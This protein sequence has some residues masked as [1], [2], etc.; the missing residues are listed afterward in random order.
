MHT[1]HAALAKRGYFYPTFEKNHQFIVSCFI[2]NPVIFDYN[3]YRSLA[4]S[5]IAVRNQSSLDL[6]ERSFAASGCQNL[7][8]SSEHL[9]FLS[10]SGIASLKDYLSRSFVNI[11]VLLYLR[12]PL[13]AIGSII[14]ERVKN[15]AARIVDAIEKPPF[16]RARHVLRSWESAF[17]ANSILVRDQHPDALRNG[18]LIDDFLSCIGCPNIANEITRVKANQSLSHP[19]TL[20][21]DQLAALHPK[22]SA[23]RAP[24]GGI[25][26]ILKQIAGPK[27][28]PSLQ[29]LDATQRAAGPD[30]SYLSQFWSLEL[31]GP[32]HRLC[33]SEEFERWDVGTLRSLAE[34]VNAL[35]L[36]H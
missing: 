9:V 24:Q 22:Y 36:T 15:G 20:I 2:D 4:A 7:L 29:I 27:Y 32:T 6:L 8:L 13:L 26:K 17:G 5:E 11:T 28:V 19:A 31:R 10:A 21:A 14:Q 12:H 1:S 3:R 33:P 30:L 35:A 18:D 34:I 23:G 16:T 25:S